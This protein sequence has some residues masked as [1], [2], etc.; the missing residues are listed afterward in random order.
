MPDLTE[1]SDRRY[2]DDEWFYF[3]I[4][5]KF[6]FIPDGNGLEGRDDYNFDLK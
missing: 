3:E 4:C 1:A 6:E 2:R 5:I